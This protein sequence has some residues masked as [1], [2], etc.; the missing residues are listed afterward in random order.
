MRP[1]DPGRQKARDFHACDAWAKIPWPDNRVLPEALRQ[2][3]HR[4]TFAALK[5]GYCH[6][7][8]IDVAVDNLTCKGVIPKRVLQH[9]SFIINAIHM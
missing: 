9:K 1:K 5:I 3:V 2:I 7:I 8:R 6:R 4:G